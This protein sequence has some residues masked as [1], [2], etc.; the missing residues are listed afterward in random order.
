MADHYRLSAPEKS[1]VCRT[2]HHPCGGALYASP[3]RMRRAV[4]PDRNLPL[5]P[6]CRLYRQ[7]QTR[8][9]WTFDVIPHSGLHTIEQAVNKSRHQGRT[10]HLSR[11]RWRRGLVRSAMLKQA[12]GKPDKTRRIPRKG[13]IWTIGPMVGRAPH[14]G[15]V[16]VRFQDGP[17]ELERS[18]PTE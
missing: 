9:K 13:Y 18:R 17:P 12:C 4:A 16:L 11:S 2:K 8:G 14:K 15:L 5:K 3:R 7:A 6:K 1:G 10:D